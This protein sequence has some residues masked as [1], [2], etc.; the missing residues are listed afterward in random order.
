M[1]RA[2]RLPTDAEPSRRERGP[3]VARPA[4]LK[5]QSSLGSDAVESTPSGLGPRRLVSASGSAE[6][7]RA[8]R[9]GDEGAEDRIMYSLLPS[10]LVDPR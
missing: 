5:P 7:L 10:E 2:P 8:Y 6:V 1:A 9:R 4:A 3:G